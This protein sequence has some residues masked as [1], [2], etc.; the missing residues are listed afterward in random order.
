MASSI[1]KIDVTESRLRC[2][3]ARLLSSLSEDEL[4]ECITDEDII[5]RTCAACEIQIRGTAASFEFAMSLL[6]SHRHENRE[7]AAFILGQLGPP[8]YKYLKRSVEPL[9]KLFV[10]PYYEVRATAVLAFSFYSSHLREEL[11]QIVEKIITLAVDPEVS[12]RLA[13]SHTLGFIY[14]PKARDCLKN[15]RDDPV[16]EIR[17]DAMYGLELYDEYLNELKNRMK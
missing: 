7:I 4:F 2:T 12:V 6:S 10:D 8:D 9:L 1:D 3:L 5:L 14:L 13:V 15:L 16:V 11:P 17:N